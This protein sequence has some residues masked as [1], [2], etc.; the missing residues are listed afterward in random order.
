MARTLITIHGIRD[1]GVWQSKLAS[2]FPTFE[3]LEIKYREFHVLGAVKLVFWPWSL[4][5]ISISLCNIYTADSVV[6]FIILA[7]IAARLVFAELAYRKSVLISI[8]PLLVISVSVILFQYTE[9]AHLTTLLIIWLSMS[10]LIL[11]IEYEEMSYSNN[12]EYKHIITVITLSIFGG[13]ATYYSALNM[14]VNN[15]YYAVWLYSCIVYGVIEPI[16][17]IKRVCRMVYSSLL[18]S[19][20]EVENNPPCIISHSLGTYLSGMLLQKYPRTNRRHTYHVGEELSWHK[21]ILV[22][23]VLHNDFPWDEVI[24]RNE[25]K[26]I[27][28]VLLACGGN[29]IV[30][31]IIRF[32]NLFHVFQVIKLG[33]T[34]SDGFPYMK[35]VSHYVND[36]NEWCHSCRHGEPA[37]VHSVVHD[38]AEHGTLLEPCIKYR[39]NFY[40]DFYWLAWMQGYNPVQYRAF[41]RICRHFGDTSLAIN[42]V[43]KDYYATLII[44]RNNC[45]WLLGEDAPFSSVFERDIFKGVDD[46]YF[47]TISNYTDKKQWVQHACRAMMKYVMKAVDARNNQIKNPR[48]M[49]YLDFRVAYYRAVAL[50]QFRFIKLFISPIKRSRLNERQ[51][52]ELEVFYRLCFNSH[53]NGTDFSHIYDSG[54]LTDETLGHADAFRNSAFTELMA[55]RFTFFYGMTFHEYLCRRLERKDIGTENDTKYLQYSIDEFASNIGLEIAGFVRDALLSLACKSDSKYRVFLNPKYAVHFALEGFEEDILGKPRSTFIE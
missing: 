11:F 23:S 49:Q 34:G 39:R 54:E 1:T 14:S 17:R 7:L 45:Q 53:A 46:R 5:M 32:L 8:S 24:N 6:S 30:S 21:L 22:A 18:N 36:V 27:D 3:H 20:T 26:R 55:T 47:A 12:I 41:Q 38:K 35:S 50:I 43:T 10:Y 48:L 37:I 2:L 28:S 44:L 25:R 4:L 9:H 31:L 19:Y 15:W 16:L 52:S 42:N 40:V 13:V 51:L 29:D 33:T